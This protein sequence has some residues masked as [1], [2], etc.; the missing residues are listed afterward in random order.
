MKQ[1]LFHL[2]KRKELPWY[3][4][5]G[6]RA[7]AILLALVVCGFVTTAMTGENPIAIYKTMWEGAFGTSRRI[8]NTLQYLALLLC[9]SLAV[10][11]AF[12]MKFWNVGGEGQVLMGGLATAACM[13]LLGDKVP[14]WILI[15]IMIVAALL[16][17][18]ICKTL[19]RLSLFI[20][21]PIP[22]YGIKCFTL[23]VGL[24]QRLS[25]L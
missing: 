15:L 25:L 14:N 22:K 21:H 3:A 7:A 5:W 17:G 13:I 12:R 16:A 10:T 2:S 23:T 8:W 19:S 11:P 4:A 6:I 18:A 1:K 9:V 24:F 20:I